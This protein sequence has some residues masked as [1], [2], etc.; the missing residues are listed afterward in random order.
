MI[1]FL[2]KCFAA[3]CIKQ[4]RKW[5]KVLYFLD[6]FFSVLTVFGSY[7]FF[8][9]IIKNS[10]QYSG[11]YVI[12]GCYMIFSTS[13]GFLFSTLFRKPE[14]HYNFAIGIFFMSLF[15]AITTYF[16]SIFYH[17]ASMN[18]SNYVNLFFIFFIVL[19]Y[20]AFNAK[21]TVQ[22]RAK[23]FLESDGIYCYFCFCTDWFSFF[24]LD[25]CFRNKKSKS[26]QSEKVIFQK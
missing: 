18:P 5:L 16:F 10:Y 25:W 26:S 7:Y 8:D 13:L 4:S 3:F 22:K 11:H 19:V 21:L 1:S 24:W 17:R 15:N 2:I 9:N 20:F 23:K 14:V 12:Q 6:C